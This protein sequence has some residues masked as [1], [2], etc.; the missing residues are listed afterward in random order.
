MMDFL[1]NATLYDLRLCATRS[2][3]HTLALKVTS[4]EYLTMLVKFR[5]DVMI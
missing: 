1:S 3:A 4:D 2:S 5:W